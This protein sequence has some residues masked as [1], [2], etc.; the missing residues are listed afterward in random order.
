VDLYPSTDD[1]FYPARAAGNPMAATA[2]PVQNLVAG[3]FGTL[4]PSDSQVV[5]GNGVYRNGGWT[6]VMSRSFATPDA[7]Q[8]A[9]S[10][11]TPIDTA[12]AVWDGGR[13]NRDGMKSVSVFVQMQITS[14]LTSSVTAARTRTILMAAFGVVIAGL[15]IGL[16][17]WLARVKGPNVEAG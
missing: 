12:F 13:D 5:M 10:R 17:L 3:G 8:P 6:V 4:T 2:G 9:F 15:A 1:L 14:E 16:V 11:S 7:L